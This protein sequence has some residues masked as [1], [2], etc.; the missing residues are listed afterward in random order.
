[1]HYILNKT[2]PINVAHIQISEQKQH[3]HQWN[4]C[5]EKNILCGEFFC[6]YEWHV[7]QQFQAYGI[8]IKGDN[9]PGMFKG[10]IVNKKWTFQQYIFMSTEQKKE[11]SRFHQK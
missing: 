11:L 7:T 8:W 3:F 1:M 5:F 9:R 4:I 10:L 2:H 6:L